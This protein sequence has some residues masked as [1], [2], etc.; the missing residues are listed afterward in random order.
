MGT[1]SGYISSG[2]RVGGNTGGAC[3]GKVSEAAVTIKLDFP[4]PLSPTTTMR[5]ALGFDFVE[6]PPAIQLIPTVP[7]NRIKRN[8][9]VN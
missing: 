2:K 9:L 4:V 1:R 8:E 5:T 6:P 3:V 7:Q